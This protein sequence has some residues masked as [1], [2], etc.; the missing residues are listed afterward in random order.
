MSGVRW[1]REGSIG[2]TL[3]LCLAGLAIAQPPRLGDDGDV[4]STAAAVRA[5]AAAAVMDGLTGP[6]RETLLRR[7]R[8]IDDRV[9]QQFQTPGGKDGAA[10]EVRSRLALV[11]VD[12]ASLAAELLADQ[13]GR[14]ATEATTAI[15]RAG[16]AIA[17]LPADGPITRAVWRQVIAM[18]RLAGDTD[19]AGR[20]LAQ[21]T[22][23]FDLPQTA[24]EVED[25]DWTAIAVQLAID[26]GDLAGA[27]QRLSSLGNRDASLSL[28][29]AGLRL[30]IAS[31]LEAEAADRIAAIRR[32]YGDPAGRRAESLAARWTG[33]SADQPAPIGSVLA[34]V[35]SSLA[36]GDRSAA[37]VQLATEAM[38]RPQA[39]EAFRLATAA[40]GLLRDER[41]AAA[42]SLLRSVV[43][44]FPSHPRA[45]EAMLQS[46]RLDAAGGAAAADVDQSLV[47]WTRQ[48]PGS[49][50]SAAVIDWRIEL[51]IQRGD[52]LAAAVIAS[53]LNHDLWT[54]EYSDRWRRMVANA[55]RPLVPTPKA[56][57]TNV[58][59]ERVAADLQAAV[60][61]ILD[62][63][64]HP[65]AEDVIQRRRWCLSRFAGTEM[66]ELSGNAD[67]FTLWRLGE[68]A[69]PTLASLKLDDDQIQRV[70]ADAWLDPG[71]AREVAMA[72]DPADRSPLT[73][74][75]LSQWSGD[76]SRA[77][78]SIDS[79]IAD[80]ADAAEVYAVAAAASGSI[81]DRST[82]TADLW[83]AAA[84]AV[85][86]GGERFHYATIR[87]CH[88]MIEAGDVVGAKALA[89][90]T[91]LTQPPTDP[92]LADEYA[93]F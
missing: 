79:A 69:A 23:R 61:Q 85:P 34:A 20:V 6:P 15:Q 83:A 36:S 75:A 9:A 22:E 60:G 55:L 67:P 51:A 56:W 17:V 24:D 5:E 47:R 38:R 25:A 86:A 21:A 93:G 18:H 10:A 33:S 91:R 84:A 4:A 89:R 12:L 71:I 64:E 11:R 16:E 45:A 74:V 58:Q 44:R 28:A 3:A 57:Q 27:E 88:A 59:R 54:T 66:L 42:A 82:R 63:L 2:W 35:R 90:Y 53:T 41:P 19:A 39:D 65:D 26:R 1:V 52:D 73:R 72:I 92:V 50:L 78:A 43:G 77:D 13:P 14:A 62:A 48:W 68:P 32:Q 31:G 87:Q 46:I 37:V 30:S 49:A 8:Q 80:G 70:I 40:A 29:L 76:A 7:L 81:G